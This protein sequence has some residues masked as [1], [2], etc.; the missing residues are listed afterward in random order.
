[1]FEQCCYPFKLALL[2]LCI[3][4]ATGCANTPSSTDQTLAL[5]SESEVS[6]IDVVTARTE[7]PA[8]SDFDTRVPLHFDV[9]A[10][11]HQQPAVPETLVEQVDE[12]QPDSEFAT[13]DWVVDESSA[14]FAA[15]IIVETHQPQETSLT[16]LAAVDLVEESPPVMMDDEVS[17][18]LTEWPPSAQVLASASELADA[19]VTTQPDLELTSELSTEQNIV[20]IN[21]QSM[22]DALP[23]HDKFQFDTD[24]SQVA[25]QEGVYLANHAAYLLANPHKVIHI[26]GHAD[27]RGA[28]TYN[29]KLSEKRAN[30][31]ADKLLELGVLKSQI[32]VIG[33]G[34]QYP[35]NNAENYAQNRR[36]ELEYADNLAFNQEAVNIE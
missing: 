19:L 23:V 16:M 7:T 8:V 24:K 25:D 4:M 29:Q 27:T 9:P 14:H 21:D 2:P 6:E 28:K 31:I 36:V 30:S 17:Q 13:D 3:A 35:L 1:M 12:T 20:V 11:T 10:L 34:D 22:D 15:P 26:K 32:K 18:E 5:L 33:L